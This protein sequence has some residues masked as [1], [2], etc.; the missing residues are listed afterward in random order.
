MNVLHA[1]VTNMRWTRF[2]GQGRLQYSLTPPFA[3]H[4]MSSPDHMHAWAVH[5]PFGVDSLLQE[6]R[7]VPEPGPG[8]VLVRVRAVALNYRDRLVIDGVWRPTGPR[9]PA[10]DGVGV[11][12]AAGADVTRVCVGDRVVASFFPRWIDGDPTPE[13]LAGSLGGTTAD[14]MLAEY[15]VLDADAVI[16]VPSYLTDAE[17][18][19]IPCAALTAWHALGGGSAVRRADRILIHGTGGVALFAVQMALGMGAEVIVTSRCEAKLERARALG[20][21]H[22]VLSRDGEW[23]SRVLE[24]TDGRGVDRVIET[25]GGEN[26]DRSLRAARIGGT[27]SLVGMVAGS[28]APVDTFLIAEK[29]LRVQGVLVGSRAMLEEMIAFLGERAITPVVDRLFA[30]DAVPDAVRYLASGTAF[31]KVCVSV[32]DGREGLGSNSR[33]YPLTE[34]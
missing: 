31:G 4:L 19:T 3:D 30:F 18:A 8:Q 7:P 13:M 22:G 29:R 1:W 5:P 26:L 15:V 10:S 28:R 20:A 12:I 11:V 25:I 32:G 16:R 17:A 24:L 9:V 6:V 33:A 21:T 27:V 2:P 34:G 23:E 14:G